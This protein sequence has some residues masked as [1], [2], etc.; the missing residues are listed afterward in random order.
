MTI[1]MTPAEVVPKISHG[2]AM[3]LAETEFARMTGLLR[4]LRPEEWQRQTICPQWDIRSMAAHV[5]GMAEAQASFRQFARDYRTASKRDGGP[6]IDAMT[7]AQVRERAALTPAQ[8]VDALTAVA[9]RAV[10]ARRR[11]PALARWAVRMSQ[12]PPFDQERWRFGYLV[13]TIFTRDTWMHRLDTCRAAGRDM[14]L[15]AEHDGRLIADVVAEWA[16]RHGQPFTLVLA[17]PAGGRWHSGDAGDRIELDALEFC[18]TLAGRIPGGGG[19]LTTMVP[20]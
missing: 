6:M 18:W 5:L 8:L 11:V 17:G 15:T 19:L 10:R 3:V 20:F 12:D 2:E 9:P 16:R 13:D 14:V 4:Q 1:T 7:A